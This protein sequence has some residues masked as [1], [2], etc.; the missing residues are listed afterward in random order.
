MSELVDKFPPPATVGTTDVLPLPAPLPLSCAMD[1]QET[2]S[3][4]LPKSKTGA[5]FLN[6]WRSLS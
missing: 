1:A 4:R 5:D 3:M 2:A 6:M